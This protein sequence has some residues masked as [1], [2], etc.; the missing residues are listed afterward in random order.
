MTIEEN[1]KLKTR[2]RRLRPNARREELLEAALTVLREKGP[3]RS[4]VEDV[5]RYAG[6]AKG[7]FYLYFSS[8]EELLL[9]L[10]DRLI[11]TYAEDMRVRIGASAG[12]TW[13][14]FESECI[15]FVDFVVELGELHEAIFHGP[16]QTDPAGKER[17]AD[18]LLAEMIDA[19]IGVGVFRPV[20]A[21]L[22]AP[23]V[24]SILHTTADGI[25]LSGG[26]AA[27]LDT[28]VGLLRAWLRR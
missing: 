24:F 11:S 2:R 16:N 6:A 8:W 13:P 27:K 1:G 17:R 12:M 7:T 23:L 18:T 14:L 3:Q 4:R 21:G 9:A 19:G 28:M 25:N 10:R 5:T 22:A 20:D 26:R 15:R